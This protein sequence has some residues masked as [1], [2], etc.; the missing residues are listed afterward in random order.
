[1]FS[2]VAQCLTKI[3]SR[4]KPPREDFFKKLG[5]SPA[6][7]T[8][9]LFVKAKQFINDK[10]LHFRDPENTFEYYQPFVIEQVVPSSISNS[11]NSPVRISGMLL[12]QFRFDDGARRD[13]GY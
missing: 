11:G 12:D 1:M 9:Q 2:T 5:R 3:K 4:E 10:T 7:I 13:V 6:P 8:S